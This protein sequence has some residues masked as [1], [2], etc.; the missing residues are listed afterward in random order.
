MAPVDKP[1]VHRDRIDQWH[2]L[3]VVPEGVAACGGKVIEILE[4]TRRARG[5]RARDVRVVRGAM[6]EC[7]VSQSFLCSDAVL[8][9]VERHGTRARQRRAREPEAH[10]ERHV[11]EHELLVQAGR[12]RA[13]CGT[14]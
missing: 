2:T 12:V 6:F 9:L 5:G 13:V 4:H 7:A 10:Q 3:H 14:Q 1:A 8:V 11:R